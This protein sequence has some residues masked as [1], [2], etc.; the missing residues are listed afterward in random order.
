MT[1]DIHIIIIIIIIDKRMIL[2]PPPES[3]RTD[4]EGW[5]KV[6]QQIDCEKC[7][8]DNNMQ[9]NKKGCGRVVQDFVSIMETGDRKCSY[10]DVPMQSPLVLSLKDGR[11]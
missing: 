11:K 5:V 3:N 1:R 2:L 8:E 7:G 4:D 9:Q 10:L 6:S